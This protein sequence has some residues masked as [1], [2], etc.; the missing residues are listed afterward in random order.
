MLIVT[1]PAYGLVNKHDQAEHIAHQYC[2]PQL[3][4]WLS[5]VG[6]ELN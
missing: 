3:N 2:S 4:A 5:G 1:C 6:V